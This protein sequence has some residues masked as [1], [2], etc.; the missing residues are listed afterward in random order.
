MNQQFVNRKVE[1][2][3]LEDKHACDEA[4]FIVIYGKQRIRNFINIEFA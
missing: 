4:H 2:K 3:F 1:L